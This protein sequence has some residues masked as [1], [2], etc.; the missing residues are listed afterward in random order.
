[1]PRMSNTAKLQHVGTLMVFALGNH[2]VAGCK[3]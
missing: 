1:M 3:V 2:F